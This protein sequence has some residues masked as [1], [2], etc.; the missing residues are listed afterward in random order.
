M[1]VTRLRTLLASPVVLGAVA[2]VGL[3]GCVSKKTFQ[4]SQQQVAQCQEEK[5]A[6]EQQVKDWEGRFDQE[7]RRWE[8]MHATVTDSL[9]AAL[10]EMEAERDRIVKLVPAQV[11]QEVQQYLD[12]YFDTVMKGF[13]RLQQ[14]NESLRQELQATNARI[15]SVGTDTTEIRSVSTSIDTK[16]EEE[17]AKRRAIAG[18]IAEIGQMVAN[19]D[20]SRINNRESPTKLGL[21]REERE[22]ITG[23]HQQLLT[24]LSELQ[25]EAQ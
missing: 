14:D 22:A 13:Q 21:N 8:T 10:K 23:F 24:A 4:A 9:P 7:S 1:N 20:Q 2:L 17:R 16:L 3:T 12:R 25:A 11:Q 6:L 19:F 15:A 5:K 18:R